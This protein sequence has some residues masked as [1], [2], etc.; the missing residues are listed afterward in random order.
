MGVHGIFYPAVL[1][2]LRHHLQH[3]HYFIR[4]NLDP[5]IPPRRIHMKLV[6]VPVCVLPNAVDIAYQDFMATLRDTRPV[7]NL[8]CYPRFALP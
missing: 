6:Y 8:A 1:L 2:S 5:Y 4:L 3:L 7:V